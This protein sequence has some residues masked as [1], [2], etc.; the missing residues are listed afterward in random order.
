MSEV[1]R[2][3]P[4]DQDKATMFLQ[5][6][7]GAGEDFGRARERDRQVHRHSGAQLGLAG[8]GHL[9]RDGV[10]GEEAAALLRGKA[11]DVEGLAFLRRRGVGGP[12]RVRQDEQSRE[13]GRPA[14]SSEH[15]AILGDFVRNMDE[16][17]HPGPRQ[18]GEQAA[19]PL[20]G[21]LGQPALQAIDPAPDPV[22]R[23][24][25]EH[26]PRGVERDA[27]NDR[28]EPADHAGRQAHDRGGQEDQSQPDRVPPIL[29][30]EKIRQWG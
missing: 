9:V 5:D 23:K 4:D 3:F 29:F 2:R 10:P 16:P 30:P 1:E 17:A 22:A 18:L 8:L 15:G 20:P 24:A 11:A 19:D 28:D 14:E 27:G 6:D 12:G 13:D 25:Q 7:V 26:E 21:P